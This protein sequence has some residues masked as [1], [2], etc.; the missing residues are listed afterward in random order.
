[1]LKKGAYG[2]PKRDPILGVFK[3]YLFTVIFLVSPIASLIFY[4][5]H[6]VNRKKT[7]KIIRYYSGITE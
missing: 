2:D 1:V 7:R 6:G 4:L 3:Y 5:V